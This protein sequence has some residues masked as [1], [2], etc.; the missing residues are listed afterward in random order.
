MLIGNKLDL[1]LKDPSARKVPETKIKAII[2]KNNILYEECSAMSGENV[3]ESFE[4]LID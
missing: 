1:V 3:K 4:K 2:E